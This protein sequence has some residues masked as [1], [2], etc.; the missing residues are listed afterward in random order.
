MCQFKSAIVGRTGELYHHWSTDA[1]E[2]IIEMFNLKEAHICRVEYTPSAGDY[3]DSGQ[4]VLRVDETEKP[5]WFEEFRERTETALKRIVEAMMVRKNRR[6][7]CGGRWVLVGEVEIG[8]CLDGCFIHQAGHAQIEYAAHAQITN[9]GHAKI[10]YAG[11][12]KIANA[13]HAKIAYAGHAQITNAGH[14]KIEYA[15]FAKI[16]YA[17]YAQ[18]TNAG[19]AKIAY[20]G[21]AKIANADDAQIEYAAFA[22][23]AN[24][25]D[26]QSE[27]KGTNE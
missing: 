19:H 2:D 13:G 17:A 3:T 14:A 5:P 8:R 16:E 22:K 25:D 11:N 6:V 18:I 15:A 4:Y 12:A 1:H 20:A 23:S 10:A 24:A 7:L 9:A 21:H 26:A 27:A